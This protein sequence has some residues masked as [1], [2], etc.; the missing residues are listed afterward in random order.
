MPASSRRATTGSKAITRINTSVAF[1]M[2]GMPALFSYVRPRRPS[3]DFIVPFS[4]GRTVQVH[5]KVGDVRP[6]INSRTRSL[7]SCGPTISLIT[8]H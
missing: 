5:A 4:G 1:S 3:G 6:R 8:L 7:F 2:F